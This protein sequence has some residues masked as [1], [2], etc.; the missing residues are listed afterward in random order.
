MFYN[1]LLSIPVLVIFSF[2][3]EDWSAKSLELNL[4]DSFSP[5]RLL[6]MLDLADCSLVFSVSCSPAETRSLLLFAMAFSGLGAVFISYSTAW[7]VRTT[8]STTYRYGSHSFRASIV[9][10]VDHYCPLQ[11][12]RCSQQTASGC[13]RPY[14]LWRPG[15]I[16]LCHWYIHWLCGRPGV[17]CCKASSV[18]EQ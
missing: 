15:H 8:S 5:F 11:H 4:Y 6:Y 9:A 3:F 10:H 1:N 13:I 17:R 18:K 12:G 14:I 16:Q 2:L 7:C